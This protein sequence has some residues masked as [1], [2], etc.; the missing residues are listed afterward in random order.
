[1]KIWKCLGG[2]RSLW[3]L[4]MAG[5]LTAVCGFGPAQADNTKFDDSAKKA[6][7]NFGEFLKGVGQEVKKA[8]ASLS[9]S[10]KKYDRNEK[11]RPENEPDK[12]KENPR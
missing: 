6:G 9:E 11:K 10:A 8:G 2:K 1:M 4:W 5:F 3:M 12:N 7:N